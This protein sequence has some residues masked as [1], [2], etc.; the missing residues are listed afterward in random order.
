MFDLDSEVAAWSAQVAQRCGHEEDIA[1]LEDHLRSAFERLSAE[2]MPAERAFELAVRRMGDV[3]EINA[4][5]EKNRSLLS[6]LHGSL[7]S[8]GRQ[9]TRGHSGQREN[10]L[11]IVFASLIIAASILLSS[12][13]ISGSAAAGYLLIVVVPLWLVSRRLAGRR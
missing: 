3:A 10:G 2:G 11:A 5:Y 1:E 4:E 6:R 13:D 12:A 8:W 9:P 7:L